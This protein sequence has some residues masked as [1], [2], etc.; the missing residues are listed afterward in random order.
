[1]L[2]FLEEPPATS[3]KERLEVLPNLL[4]H[5]IPIHGHYTLREDDANF[6]EIG[7]NFFNAFSRNRIDS[8]KR[9]E[10][11]ENNCHIEVLDTKSNSLEVYGLNLL[12]VNYKEREFTNGDQTILRWSDFDY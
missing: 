3:L 12:Q 10:V 6:V 5:S 4:Q 9:M 7:F 2:I 8:L 11:F 1:V